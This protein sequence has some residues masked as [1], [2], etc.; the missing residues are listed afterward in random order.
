MCPSEQCAILCMQLNGAH[1]QIKFFGCSKAIVSKILVS[2]LCEI[3]PCAKY[4]VQYYRVIWHRIQVSATDLVVFFFKCVYDLVTPC[5]LSTLYTFL[6][7]KSNKE[8]KH[9]VLIL[10]IA[11]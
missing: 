10:A 8:S 4:C 9:L 6:S 3:E 5:P 1:F 11:K 2:K 7:I